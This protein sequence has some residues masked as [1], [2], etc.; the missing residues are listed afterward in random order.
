M[1]DPLGALKKFHEFLEPAGHAFIWVPDLV[2][3]GR[4]PYRNFQPGHLHGFTYETL[5][6]MAAKAG[7]EVPYDG[8]RSTCLLLRRG[9]G[10]DPNW[11]RFPGHAERLKALLKQQT[12]W[13]YLCSARS[14]RRIPTRIA[15]WFMAHLMGRRMTNV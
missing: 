14:W 7:F 9:S 1:R 10:P 13:R 3:P 12:V 11:F 4:W 6:M 15:Y 5:V 8:P 2:E